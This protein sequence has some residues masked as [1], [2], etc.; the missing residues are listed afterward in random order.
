MDDRRRQLTV[1]EGMIN[2][3]PTDS[4]YQLN[5]VRALRDL[6]AT[7]RDLGQ[8]AK[9]LATLK[10]AQAIVSALIRDNPSNTQFKE[11]LSDVFASLAD[12][13]IRN[14]PGG[15]NA[16]IRRGRRASVEQMSR[17]DPGNVHWLRDSPEATTTS[18]S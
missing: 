16:G 5:R 11:A 12:S 3:H 7:E 18:L 17:A 14:G 6:A 13:G 8:T 9:A 2:T 1:L 15:G 4:Q 10:N